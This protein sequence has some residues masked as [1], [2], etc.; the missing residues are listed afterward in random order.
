MKTLI[1]LANVLLLI[2]VLL[3]ALQLRTDDARGNE[4]FDE[5]ASHEFIRG[6]AND[7][8]RINIADV[9]FGLH[10]QKVVHRTLIR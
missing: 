6:D 2:G 4:E 7:D 8:N 9:V 1:T 5:N 3:L 10:I